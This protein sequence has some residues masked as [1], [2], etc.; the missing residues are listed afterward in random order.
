MLS[1]G[2]NSPESIAVDTLGNAYIVGTGN[3]T[4]TLNAYRPIL[5][6]FGAGRVNYLIKLNSMGVAVYSTY[7]WAT[8]DRWGFGPGRDETSTWGYDQSP[9]GVALLGPDRVL[10]TGLDFNHGDNYPAYALRAPCG[11][12]GP[13]K[14]GWRGFLTLMD[15]SKVGADSH[16]ATTCGGDGLGIG[17]RDLVVTGISAAG[18]TAYVV[19][20]DPGFAPQGMSKVVVTMPSSTGAPVFDVKPG[21]PV[22]RG[23]A[24]TA[25]TDATGGVEAIYVLDHGDTQGSAVRRFDPDLTNPLLYPPHAGEVV[26]IA[27][28]PGRTLY[29]IGWGGADTIRPTALAY[30]SDYK[31]GNDWEIG[32][33]SDAFLLVLGPSGTGPLYATYL[34]GAVIPGDGT[35]TGNDLG[36]TIAVKGSDV[37]VGGVTNS[38]SFPTTPNAYQRESP[39]HTITLA[40]P[41]AGYPFDFFAA[42]FSPGSAAPGPTTVLPNIPGP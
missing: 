9:A 3:I 36:T 8:N 21:N 17:G 32:T 5:P 23:F 31:G 10:V 37:Y 41:G 39:M 16:V 11:N 27:A 24:V 6:P 26:D 7:L 20:D 19:G 22:A 14:G 30:Q 40:S 38:P 33:A 28:G 18:G 15:T 29:E 4:A 35:T 13:D 25:G 42:R 34:G 1:R 12:E 2:R